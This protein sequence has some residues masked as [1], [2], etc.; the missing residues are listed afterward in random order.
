MTRSRES[1]ENA[2]HTVLE[3]RKMVFLYVYALRVTPGNSERA[4]IVQLLTLFIVDLID[5]ST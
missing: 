3:R 2:L 5:D 4:S 1:R